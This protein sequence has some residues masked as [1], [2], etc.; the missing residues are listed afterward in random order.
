MK[1]SARIQVN[2]AFLKPTQSFTDRTHEE[3]IFLEIIEERPNTEKKQSRP[4]YEG[5]TTLA[6]P[7]IC[8]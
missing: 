5:E 3:E 8:H 7:S 6:N 1:L 4:F 2:A